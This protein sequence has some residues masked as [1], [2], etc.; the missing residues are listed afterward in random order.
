M[1]KLRCRK[2]HMPQS[3]LRI[4]FNSKCEV[5]RQEEKK[6]RGEREKRRGREGEGR[7]GKERREVKS[8]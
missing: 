4:L 5:A 2:D 3:I 6:G 8:V 7:E 1:P